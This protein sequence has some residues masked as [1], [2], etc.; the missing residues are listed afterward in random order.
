MRKLYF[1]NTYLRSN[2]RSLTR[3]KPLSRSGFTLIEVLVAV[4]V[5]TIIFS[6]L[7]SILGTMSS[8]WSTSRG[9]MDN[10][11][12]ARAILNLMHQDLSN[13][14]IRQDL[15]SFTENKKNELGFFV[16]NFGQRKESKSAR[17]LTYVTYGTIEINGRKVLERVDHPYDFLGGAPDW[18][19]LTSEDSLG[20]KLTQPSSAIRRDVCEGVLAFSYY[21]I[22]ENGTSSRIFNSSGDDRTTAVLVAFVVASE[23]AALFLQELDKTAELSKRLKDLSPSSDGWKVKASWQDFLTAPETYEEYPPEILSNI[24]VYQRVTPISPGYL[25]PSTTLN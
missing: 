13:S 20:F 11:S 6:I 5:L 16:R 21:F 10:F 22:N 19:S 18:Q 23:K 1:D 4:S 2:K 7:V 12:K 3:A 17:P 14:V 25:V 8:A 15:P 9:K 24:R